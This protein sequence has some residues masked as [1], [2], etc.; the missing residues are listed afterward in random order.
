MTQ[1]PQSE[2]DA[3][4]RFVKKEPAVSSPGAEDGIHPMSKL[5]FAW[6]E[7]PR[8]P[9]FL[10]F[11][12]AAILIVLTLLEVSLGLQ[13]QPVS[14]AQFSAFYVVFGLIAVTFAT[15]S[16]WLLGRLLRRG[17][18]YYDEGDTTPFDV[19]VGDE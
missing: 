1:T 17:E 10:I 18:N 13:L 6:V 14:T 16:A 8:V 2:R 9:I 11:G 5:L 4:G 15:L 19:E 3:S 12:A 7:H